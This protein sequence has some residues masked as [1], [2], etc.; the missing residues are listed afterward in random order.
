[1]ARNASNLSAS[2]VTTVPKQLRDQLNAPLGGR[3]VWTLLPDGNLQAKLCH[4]TVPPNPSA[5]VV[6]YAKGPT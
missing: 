6:P 5:R 2:S 4:A 1:M 3:L